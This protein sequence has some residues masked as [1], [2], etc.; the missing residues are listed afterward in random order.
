M[1][2]A[3]GGY[4]GEEPL[5]VGKFLH[6]QGV[7]LNTGRNALEYIL[8]QLS[9][10]KL[11]YLPFYTCK[12]VLEPL[13]K[14]HIPYV[15]YHLNNQF[16]I[17]D[18]IKL[19]DGEYIIVNNYFGIMDTYAE[20]MAAKYG[21]R[22]IIDCA[23]AFFAPVL[24]HI[25]MFYSMR[26]YVG[27]ADGGVA[28]PRENDEWMLLDIDD[29]RHR[30]DHLKIRNVD[31]AEAGFQFYQQ[32]ESKLD[33]QEILQIAPR[34]KYA[35]QNMDYNTIIAKRIANYQLLQSALKESNRLILPDTNTFACPM[36]Y[37]YWPM[38]DIDV[39]KRLQ[40]NRIYT[41]TYWPNVI[42]TND[43]FS[44]ESDLALNVI[45]LPIDQRYGAVEMQ[46][47]INQILKID[48]IR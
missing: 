42:K 48:E 10:V 2:D 45:P 39:R 3:I 47:I 29:N 20:E 41:A 15:Y 36:V 9:Y 17:A 11:V 4:F 44:L 28:Y 23:Q 14:L 37:P 7:L 34:T 32:N 21:D 38:D 33:N 30:M 16:K 35:L 12:V 8:E 5:G 46:K 25:K 43:E 13:H 6:Q 19:L 24:P 26:K 22:L 27:V 31:G 1:I 40:R 18:D